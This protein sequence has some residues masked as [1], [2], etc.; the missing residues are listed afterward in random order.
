MAVPTLFFGGLAALAGPV[1]CYLLIAR[2]L[3]EGRTSWVVLGALCGLPW[4]LVVV[5]ALRRALKGR[6]DGARGG[7]DVGG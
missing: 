5:S 2:G 6:A 1:I 4:L 3:G 7:G